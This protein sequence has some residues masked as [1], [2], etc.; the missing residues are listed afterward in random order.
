MSLALS[1]EILAGQALLEHKRAELA[2]NQGKPQPVAKIAI[3]LPQPKPAESDSRDRKDNCPTKR[4]DWNGLSGLSCHSHDD[5]LIHPM[6]AF[7]AIKWHY[8]SAFR[9]WTIARHIDHKGSGWIYISD[10]REYLSAHEVN[11]RKRQHWLK[12]A[13]DTGFLVKWQDR[14]KLSILSLSDVCKRL[15]LSAPNLPARIKI[16]DFL[17]RRWHAYPYAGLRKTHNYGLISQKTLAKRIKLSARTQRRYLRQTPQITRRKNYTR[18]GLKADHLAIEREYGGKRPLVVIGG[19]IYKRLPDTVSV[20]DEIARPNDKHTTSHVNSDK[21][22]AQ[23]VLRI[24]AQDKTETFIRL[25]HKSLKGAKS[26]VRKLDK[27]DIPAQ[28]KPTHVFYPMAGSGSYRLWDY[29]DAGGA[30]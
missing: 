7:A 30:V 12:A 15:G 28:E 9:A 11:A 18:T 1:P 8:E 21:D 26:Q 22:K 29:L 19:E 2:F 24:F 6:L 25:F 14:K 13:L 27:S 10:W 3:P 20:P 5:L 16:D 4:A 17:K 23:K